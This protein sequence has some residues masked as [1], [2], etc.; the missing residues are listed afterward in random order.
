M[1]RRVSPS[2][3]SPRIARDLH[4]AV[5]HQISVIS[6]NAGAASTALEARPEK[7]RE[8]LATIR[9]AS[10]TVLG[11]IGDLMAMLRQG[12]GEVA[13]A[14]QR[15][16][17]SLDDLVVSFRASGL[18]VAMRVEG[19]VDTVP[20]SVS[21]VAYRVVQEGLTNALKHGTER[22]AHVLIERVGEGLHIVV[23]NPCDSSAAAR[24]TETDRGGGYG[25]VGLRERV[26]AVRGTVEAGLTPGGFRLSA[27]L[28]IAE[29]VS[30]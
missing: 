9:S 19:D 28:P 17:D 2:P 1:P 29:Q 14:P 18:E 11:E 6:L 26:A 8:A 7:A 3:K 20:A 13:P 23:T 25:L 21:R 27:L 30:S 15:S 10:R 4:D 12:D 24:T 22:R 16:L 5:A